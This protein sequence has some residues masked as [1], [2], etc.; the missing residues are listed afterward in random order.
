M[1]LPGID[2]SAI[3]QGAAFN[4]EAWRGK[5]AFAGIKATQGLT[6]KDPDFNR[7]M[8]GA[9]E[10]GAARM[11]YH[12]FDPSED[13]QAQARYFLEYADPQPGELVMLDFETPGPAGAPLPAAAVADRAAAFADYVRV[14]VGAWPVA[15]SDQWMIESGYCAKLGACPAFV[16]NPSRV[17]LPTVLG[18]WRLVSFQQIGQRGVDTDVFFGDLAALNRL[19]VLHPVQPIKP[20]PI[21]SWRL[22]WDGKKE[23]Q[24]VSI[25]S[26]DDGKT[27]H[28]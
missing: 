11:P 17:V 21:G 20:I 22:A 5:I 13:G 15:Y 6:F 19:A 2:V 1:T 10:I 25:T 12:F 28:N 18:P 23:P 24:L 3:G 14:Q 16:A 27:W 9:R 4:W 8:N 26:N 7:N